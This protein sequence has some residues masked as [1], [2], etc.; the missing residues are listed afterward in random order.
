[1]HI[2]Q[3]APLTCHDG[4]ERAIHW[5]AEELVA[6]GHEVTLH[7][8]TGAATPAGLEDVSPQ[9]VHIDDS[10]KHVAAPSSLTLE[11]VRRQM[12]RYDF[13]HFHSNSHPFCFFSRQG[14]P[15]ITTLHGHLDLPHHGQV[16]D[17]FRYPPAV[18]ISDA[19]RRSVPQTNWIRTI[20]Y[21]LP[22]QLLTPVPVEPN[23][24]AFLGRIGP[25][26]GI[27]RV[28]S[29]AR[30]SGVPIRIAARINKQ[31]SEYFDRV[32]VPLLDGSHAEYIGEVRDAEKSEFLSG[33][34]AMLDLANPPELHG[35]PIIEAMACGTPVIAFSRGPA[36]EMVDDGWTGFIVDDERGAIEAV[37]RLPRLSRER[38]RSRFERCFTA[39]QMALE[40]IDV[41]RS[42]MDYHIHRPQPPLPTRDCLSNLRRAAPPRRTRRHQTSAGWN[43]LRPPPCSK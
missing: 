43:G 28:I 27:D 35:L 41:Y 6:L 42:L 21:G 36:L 33:A 20:H 24:L 39:R 32:I 7:G 8:S 1:M 10:A 3:I 5:L 37:D 26:T 29:I 13:V 19:Q 9:A 4:M 14:T 2:A 22:Q 31:N 30:Q 15:S 18:S 34:I 16:F 12:E 25:E 17:R 23:Y 11:Q 40:Y 38:I